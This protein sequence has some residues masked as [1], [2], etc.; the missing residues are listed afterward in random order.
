MVMQNSLVILGILD[1]LFSGV[2]LEFSEFK[3]SFQ[4]LFLKRTLH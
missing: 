3:G 2:T 1:P 4:T